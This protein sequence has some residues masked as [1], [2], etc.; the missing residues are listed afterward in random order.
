MRPIT[1]DLATAPDV[2]VA[3]AALA[4][5]IALLALLAPAQVAQAQEYP[6]LRAGRWEL[7]REQPGARPVPMSSMCIDDASQRQML[8]TA[9]IMMQGMCSR[10]DVRLSRQGGTGDYV[11]SIG[12][13]TWRSKTQ[14]TLRGDTGYRFEIDSSFDPP[15]NGQTRSRSVIDGR[16][17]GPCK[18]GQQP[19]DVVMPNGRTINMRDVTGGSRRPVPPPPTGQ[20]R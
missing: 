2:P 5:A 9:L 6:K 17:T 8:D 10:H 19:G 13:T 7:M 11:C 4:G 3:R 14:L 1:R 12:G 16:H 20:P 15:K 18:A